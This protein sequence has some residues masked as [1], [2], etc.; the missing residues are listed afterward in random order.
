M[1]ALLDKY[2]TTDESK[3][4]TWFKAA[5]VTKFPENGGACVK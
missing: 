2:F 3:V 5:A 1:S 4:T